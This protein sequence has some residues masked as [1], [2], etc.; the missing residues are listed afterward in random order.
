M[1]ARWLLTVSTPT[2][3]PHGD[4]LVAQAA[5]EQPEGVPLAGGE[6]GEAVPRGLVRFPLGGVLP[7]ELDELGVRD[8]RRAAVDAADGVAD[9]GDRGRLVEHGGGPGGDGAREVAPAGAGGED[10]RVRPRAL[11][12]QL[13]DEAT[14]VAVRQV[15]VEDGHIDAAEHGPG[16]R[17][18]AGVAEDAQARLE[19]EGQRQGLP[20]GRVVLQQEEPDVA[21]SLAHGT[22]ARS[23]PKTAPWP[24]C[25]ATVN[26]DPCAVTIRRA[27]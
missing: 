25:D 10:E 7:E 26:S 19:R 9:L 21:V 1:P 2:P 20:E 17:E 4:L 22:T 13:A 12:A 27:R 6:A 14:A 18:G 11:G 23:K 16:G 5:T 8:E 24:G 15:E 3:K